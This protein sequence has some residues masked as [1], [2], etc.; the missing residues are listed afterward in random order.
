VRQ[1]VQPLD[2][3]R[4]LSTDIETLASAIEQG[5]FTSAPGGA[6]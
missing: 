3:D 1:L 5:H 4:V 6:E 2:K